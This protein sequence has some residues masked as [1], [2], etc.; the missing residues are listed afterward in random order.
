MGLAQYAGEALAVFDLLA[1]TGAEGL[2]GGH[3]LT[4]VVSPEPAARRGFMGLAV[5]EALHVRSILPEE[6][7]QQDR[8]PVTGVVRSDDGD[9]EIVDPSRIGLPSSTGEDDVPSAS[10][11]NGGD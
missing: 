8:G 10:G 11:G 5:Q 4:L 9:I 6:I 3:A 2:R 1:L 7:E